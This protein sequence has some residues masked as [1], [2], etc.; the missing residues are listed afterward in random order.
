MLNE[1]AGDVMTTALAQQ[2]V[3]GE[4]LLWHERAQQWWWTDIESSR[5]L[6]WTPSSGALE[7]FPTMDRVGCFAHCV[8]GKILLGSAKAL[9]L[10]DVLNT[11]QTKSSRPVLARQLVAVD[12]LESRTR[13][14]DG[15][16]D[17]N[18]NFVFGTMN[19]AKDKRPIGSFYQYSM[20]HQLRRLALPAAAISNSICFSPNGST[21]YFTDTLTRR[22]MQCNYDSASAQV[23][24]IRKFTDVTAGYPDGSVID[25]DG[26]LWNAQ[27]GA[28]QVVQYAPDGVMM[29]RIAVPTKNPTCPAF[30]GPDLNQLAVTSSRQEM[31]AD[32]L[33]AMPLAGS[34]FSVHLD[35]AT[36]IPDT[37]FNDQRINK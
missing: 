7:V 13:I 4:G 34:L 15:R 27:W 12:P 26:C 3:L 19:E 24:D 14:N 10:T 28:A 30:G 16:T 37:L 23:S 6:A 33:I 29:Q 25:S 8:S 17:R 11:I 18:G 9:G 20:Q 35:R 22:I 36:G 21:M 2:A 31:S 1:L 5:L 32:E